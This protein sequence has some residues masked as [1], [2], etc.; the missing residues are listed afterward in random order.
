MMMMF[1]GGHW[2][3]LWWKFYT[4]W[5]L[6]KDLTNWCCLGN[7]DRKKCCLCL[8]E[9]YRCIADENN[10]LSIFITTVVRNGEL[11]LQPGRFR[12]ESVKSFLV[13]SFGWSWNLHSCWLQSN[14]LWKPRVE[15]VLPWTWGRWTRWCLQV[16]FSPYFPV[17][18]MLSL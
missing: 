12:L 2:P 9:K 16:F 3:C 6:R 17:I 11:K 13:D 10:V 15:L 5:P 14:V 7:G 4:A 8:H 18:F 1:C